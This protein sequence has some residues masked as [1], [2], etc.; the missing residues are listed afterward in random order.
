M[1]KLFFVSIVVLFAFICCLP[2]E[3]AA[4]ANSALMREESGENYELLAVSD[5]DLSVSAEELVFDFTIAQPEYN[6]GAPVGQVAANYTMQNA[7]MDKTVT[8]GFPLVSSIESFN[9]AGSVNVI[10]NGESAD[11]EVRYL[12][13]NDDLDIG[14]L[15]FTDILGDVNNRFAGYGEAVGYLYSFDPGNFTRDERFNVSFKIPEGSLVINKEFNG[16]TYGERDGYYNISFM[17]WSSSIHTE[18]VSFFTIGADIEELYLYSCNNKEKNKQAYDVS[19]CE[20]TVIKVDDY[21]K[22]IPLSTMDDADAYATDEEE[23]FLLRAAYLHNLQANNG[24]IADYYQ[25][26]GIES[27]PSLILLIYTVE[28]QPGENTL[29]VTYP[30]SNGGYNDYYKPSKFDYHYI[31]NPAKGWASFGTLTVRV[32]PGEMNPYVIDSSLAFVK[33]EDGS[34]LYVGEGV[35]ENN[36]SFT[37]CASESPVYHL[38]VNH[39]SLWYIITIGGIVAGGLAAAAAIVLLIVFLKKKRGKKTA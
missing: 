11:F 24:A 7:G 22:A 10:S 12:T 6:F 8:M 34:Y 2:A 39:S 3:S 28:L 15:G 26:S 14:D 1:K 5:P 31:S 35:P 37:I 19:L 29:S 16:I 30:I 36:I 17:T 9:S 4:V 32:L 33:Q 25:L 23:L 27:N 38:P 21:I 18:T 20:R 13:Y